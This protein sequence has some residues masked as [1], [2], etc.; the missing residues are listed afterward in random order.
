MVRVSAPP[1][2]AP[3]NR[4][5]SAEDLRARRLGAQTP[6][7]PPATVTI[8]EDG[9]QPPRASRARPGS[10]ALLAL[11]LV[12]ALAL[13]VWL[14]RS[15]ARPSETAAAGWSALAPSATRFARLARQAAEDAAPDLSSA[16]RGV[17]VAAAGRADKAIQRRGHGSIKGGI[18]FVP[19]SFASSDGAYD[20]L[21][22][23]H[24]N[25]AVVRESAEVARLNAIVA[26]VNLGVGSAPYQDAYAAPGTYEALLADVQR[27]VR[28]RGLPGARLRR[29][30][31]SSWSAG[32]GALSTILE[33]RRGAEPL[34]AL[35]V[36]DG[37][38]CGFR[39]E[40]PG[41]LNDRQLASFAAA[42]R[43]A[44]GRQILF[45]ITHT[46]IEPPGYASAAATA[47]YLL[48]TAREVGAPVMEA[49]AL[50]AP[51]HLALRAAEGAVSKR[52]EKRLEPTADRSAGALR[53]R[54][55]RG[56]TPEH[57][58]SHLLQMGA[59]VLPELAR[60]W[61][62]PGTAVARG[63]ASERRRR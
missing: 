44:A 34:D 4:R 60:R 61:S 57:H 6:T 52:L 7:P 1:A 56:N 35:L 55:F 40:D 13:G 59:T 22:H 28:D 36:L 53:V 8:A 25:T 45:S 18:L 51:E 33:V 3:P 54:G 10:R 26:V 20:L 62:L 14:A 48:G 41:H 63:G 38:H 27:V 50:R 47:E 17:N 30:A 29:V 23:F 9:R 31:L 16:A 58:M 49:P 32:Y 37:I 46:E 19:D 12:T 15:L 11:L 24:G 2:A 21:L 42:A 5:C 39:E 43:S